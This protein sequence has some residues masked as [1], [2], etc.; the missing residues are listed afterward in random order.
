MKKVREHHKKKAKEL[1]RKPTQKK[2]HIIRKDPGVPAN[3]PFKEQFVTQV[4]RAR[5]AMRE[6][7]QELKSMAQQNIPHPAT[8]ALAASSEQQLAAAAA[9]SA[10]RYEASEAA[11][12]MLAR[13]SQGDADTDRSRRAFYKEFVRVVE[14]SDVVLH[15]L[16]ARDPV[17]CRCAD[18]ER[19]VIRA[20]PNKRVILVLNKVDLVPREAAEAWL[21]YLREELPSIAFKC[22]TQEQAGKLAAASK[23]APGDKRKRG[24]GSSGSDKS[25]ADADGA[26]TSAALGVD[27]LLQLLKNYA[28]RRGVNKG[29]AA[30]KAAITVGVVG[31]PNV[32]KSSLI[33]SLKR[34]RV[35]QV[36]NVAGVT[37]HAQEIHLDK[38]V[39]LLD[40]PGVVFAKNAGVLHG[41]VRYDRLTDPS[42]AV[43]EVIARCPKLQ[44][45]RHYNLPDYA[46]ATDDEAA[47]V[48]AFLGAVARARG[49]LRRGGVPD[50]TAAAR[51]VLGDWGS[52]ALPYYTMPP[53]SRPGAD[54]VAEAAVVA[55]WGQD[56]ALEAAYA[57]ERAAVLEVLEESGDAVLVKGGEAAGD[58]D[59]EDGMED[60]EEEDVED[61]E[62]MDDDEFA[63][64]QEDARAAAAGKMAAAASARQAD[65]LYSNSD[66]YDPRLAKKARKRAKKERGASA[67]AAAAAVTAAGGGG[68]DYTF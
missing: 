63:E 14:A 15:V 8:A 62:E 44:L 58:M 22:N 21:K 56:F 5:N 43:K 11:G 61:V 50:R 55:G 13:Q 37:R 6:R 35:A 10:S 24:G 17:A 41:A 49:K 26:G 19:F 46:A 66:Q 7:E 30:A 45:M 12:S 64:L 57:G 23:R 47:H 51:L 2:E 25:S 65:L 59:D 68:E 27:T 40:S 34:S 9:A 3:Y 20:N 67:A 52:G 60:D 48:E 38:N 28:R 36:G 33:N 31:M 54:A 32:G 18:V 39:T 42:T 53:K 4:E 16:D 29:S 1:R